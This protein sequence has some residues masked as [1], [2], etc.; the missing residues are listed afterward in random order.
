MSSDPINPNAPSYYVLPDGT[1]LR[2]IIRRFRG[3]FETAEHLIQAIVEYAIRAGNKPGV[4][5]LDD[6]RKVL[7][8]AQQLVN[9][10][11]GR[12]VSD[13]GTTPDHVADAGKMVAAPPPAP[14]FAWHR[15]PEPTPKPTPPRK[16]RA[17]NRVVL[18]RGCHDTIGVVMGSDLIDGRVCVN[19]PGGHRVME[20]P[21]ALA[22][23]EPDQPWA[24]FEKPPPEPAPAPTPAGLDLSR[25]VG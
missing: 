18:V 13:D 16:F 25:V 7:R 15:E 19:W 10:L 5:M 23:A 9:V 22:P 20:C 2:E 21:A 4:A 24:E 3:D 11:E 8:T 17:G 1:E 12:H 6:A 14:S